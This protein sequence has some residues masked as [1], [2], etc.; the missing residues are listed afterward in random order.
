MKLD[1]L[2]KLKELTDE[3]IIRMRKE[4]YERVQIE[5]ENSELKLRIQALQKLTD[6]LE[7]GKFD[8]L[9]QE[10]ER[11]KQKNNKAKVQLQELIAGIE[12]KAM[13]SGVD[14]VQEEIV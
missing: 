4:R 12:Q 13:V 14:S 7:L 8:G 3:L 6:D 9:L 1:Q 2:D 10:N 11:L 5:R